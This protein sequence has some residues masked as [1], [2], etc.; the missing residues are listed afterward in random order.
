M[1]YVPDNLDIF[2]QYEA[3]MERQKR[4][5]RRRAYEWGEEDEGLPFVSVP[6]DYGAHTELY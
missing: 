2:E 1:D 3:E 4:V 6:D 5:R